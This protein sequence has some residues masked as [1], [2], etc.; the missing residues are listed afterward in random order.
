[1][2]N[3]PLPCLIIGGQGCFFTVSLDAAGCLMLSDD[4]CSCM[5]RCGQWLAFS[6]VLVPRHT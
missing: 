4:F 1:M 2:E 5:L 6:A 3:L